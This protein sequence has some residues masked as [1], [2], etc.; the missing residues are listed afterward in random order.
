[1]SAEEKKEKDEENPSQLSVAQKVRMER[2]RQRALLLRSARLTAHPYQVPDQGA[3]AEKTVRVGGSRVIDTGG[4]FFMEEEEEEEP[5]TAADLPQQQGAVI[6]GTEDVCEECRKKFSDSYLLKSFDV[7][8]C[9]ECR[10]NDTFKLITKTEAKQKYCLKDCDF[11]LREPALKFIV[12]KNPHNERWGDMKLYLELQVYKRAMEVWGDEEK[13]EDQKEKRND[14]KDK[15]KRKK[16]EKRIK[17]LRKAVRTSTWHKDL[18]KH[19]H[20]YDSENEVYDEEEDMYTKQ[21]KTCDHK[22]TYEKM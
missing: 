8:A 4:G 17:E 22:V 6:D 20:E 13:L 15:V 7:K 1:M 14:N 2:N 19:V 16:F 5:L 10:Y 18:S 9:D 11:E 3:A 21:C 12:R